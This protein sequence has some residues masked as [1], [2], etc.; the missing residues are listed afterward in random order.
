[1]KYEIQIITSMTFNTETNQWGPSNK[2][3][4]TEEQKQLLEI[5]CD[6]EINHELEKIYVLNKLRFKIV[7]YFK[8]EEI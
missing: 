1:M 4:I 7:P 5:L 2:I 8:S 3:L 6:M